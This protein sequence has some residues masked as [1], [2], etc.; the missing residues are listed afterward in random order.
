MN[1]EAPLRVPCSHPARITDTDH[2]DRSCVACSDVACGDYE[3]SKLAARRIAGNAERKRVLQQQVIQANVNGR[4]LEII[5]GPD[6]ELQATS[7]SQS[8]K[9]GSHVR[10]LDQIQENCN[11]RWFGEVLIEASGNNALTR[12]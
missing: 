10:V 11:V 8:A 2:G 4:V 6:G 5:V 12:F 3:I 7:A 1:T 9:A